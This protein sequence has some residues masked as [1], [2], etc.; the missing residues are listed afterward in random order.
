MLVAARV[1]TCGSVSSFLFDKK[2][3]TVL[4]NQY[5]TFNQS[6][7]NV[8]PFERQITDK[9]Q[10][11]ESSRL[12]RIRAPS[13]SDDF[14]ENFLERIDYALGSSSSISNSAARGT[15]NVVFFVDVQVEVLFQVGEPVEER[16]IRGAGVGR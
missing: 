9:S 1:L 10:P 16:P 6:D 7:S 12:A 5:A 2:F 14:A 4:C 15:Q 13:E 11:R 3:A 8:N